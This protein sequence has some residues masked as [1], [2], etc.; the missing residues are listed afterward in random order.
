MSLR[1][2]VFW[3][4]SLFV[5]ALVP[6]CTDDSP[7]PDK[8][9]N[10][11]SDNLVLIS[12]QGNFGWG[13]GTLSLYDAS[14]Q[15]IENEV[16]QKTND[17]SLG[18]VFQSITKIGSEYYLVINNS[19]KIVVTDS[20]FKKKTEITGLTSP[21]RC[22]QVG[23]SKAY[24]TDLYSDAITVIN[25]TTNEITGD[26]RIGGATEYGVVFEDKFWCVSEDTDSLYAI[27]ISTNRISFSTYVGANP[28]GIEITNNE[29]LIILCAGDSEKAKRPS[30]VVY[31]IKLGPIFMLRMDLDSDAEPSSLAYSPKD[32]HILFCDR[33]K[34]YQVDNDNAFEFFEVFDFEGGTMYA[35]DV[36]R[37][38]GEI[39]AS[40]AID[41]VSKSKIYRISRGYDL[42]DDFSAGIITGDFFFP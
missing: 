6:S 8:A 20:L 18:N 26:I 13:E 17:E 9:V 12:N 21:R 40:D 39:Y 31:S 2:V 42:L 5:L 37:E 32:N 11:S 29:D 25:T 15:T 38:T 30:V 23:N 22:Y 16:Y 3:I 7:E 34:L 28:I 14:N 35:L 41:F 27:D 36:N 4:S 10:K 33:G 19:G 24:V 1:Y